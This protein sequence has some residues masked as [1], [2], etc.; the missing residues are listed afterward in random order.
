MIKKGVQKK[1]FSIFLVPSSD[2]LLFDS[3]EDFTNKLRGNAILHFLFSEI[4]EPNGRCSEEPKEIV[5]V[6]MS[7][8]LMNFNSF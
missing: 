4:F 5:L 2:S 6:L 7:N 1:S 8:G 3:K